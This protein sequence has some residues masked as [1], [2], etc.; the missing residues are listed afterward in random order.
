MLSLT[1]FLLSSVAKTKTG[2]QSCEQI[3][4]DP[5]N[6]NTRTSVRRHCQSAFFCRPQAWLL[7]FE[8]AV[9]VASLRSHSYFTDS[10]DEPLYALP[11]GLFGG[12]GYGDTVRLASKR[13]SARCEQYDSH[14]LV[15]ALIAGQKTAPAR[16][17]G[18]SREKRQELLR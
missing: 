11:D 6:V 1:C 5:S 14:Y 3:A 16:T 10:A 7:F 2:I 4:G 18:S 17:S 8:I 13:C 15:F 9:I 12:C